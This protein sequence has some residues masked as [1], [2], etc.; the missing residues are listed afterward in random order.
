MRGT[1]IDFVIVIVYFVGILAFGSFFARYTR[2]T[3]DF[4]FGGQRFSWWIIAFSLVAT[5]VGSYS[6]IKYSAAGFRYGMSSSMTYL[7]DWIVMSIL[8]LGWFPISGLLIM[9]AAVLAMIA[10]N[11]ALRPLYDAL[12]G[13]PLGVRVGG[14][15][16]DKPLLLWINDG[17]MAVFF[18]LIGL[19]IKREVLDGELSDP[20]KVALPAIAAVGGMLVPAAFYVYFNHGDPEAMTGW[21]IPM[22]FA[23]QTGAMPPPVAWLLFI[24]ALLWTTAY[25]TMYAMADREDD[26]RIGVKSSA[27]LFGEADRLII[28]ILQFLFILTLWLVG[29]ELNFSTIYF[30]GLIFAA[31]LLAYQQAMIVYRV[32]EF[33]FQAFLHNHWVGAVV[34]FGIMGHYYLA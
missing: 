25:D 17:M 33:C 27:I 11:T 13:I 15:A 28:G 24:A 22:A 23:A 10:E 21:A 31:V 26:L 29:M 6:F 20:R 3:K 4:F 12:L 5:T 1:P 2:S 16:I 34:F 8:L 19:E 32:P 18:F 14:L 30:I 7:N 9:G